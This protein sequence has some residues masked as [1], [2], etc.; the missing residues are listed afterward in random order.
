MNIFFVV[1]LVLL[2]CI[3]GMMSFPLSK[4]IQ[5]VEDGAICAKCGCSDKCFALKSFP[6]GNNNWLDEFMLISYYK[7]RRYCKSAQGD[8]KKKYMIYFIFS[9]ILAMILFWSKGISTSSICFGISS[10]MLLALGIVDWNTQYIPLEYTLVITLCGLIRLFADFTNW[11]EYIIGLLAVS[12][13]LCIVNWIATPILRKKYKDDKLSGVIGDGDIKLMAA[14]GLLIGWKLN[15]IAL[16]VA[17]VIG[18]V[19][20]LARMRIKGSEPIFA[21]GP[22]LSVGVYIT[23]IYGEQLVSWYLEMLGVDPLL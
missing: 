9:V 10:A 4:Y 17:C 1:L 8:Y 2:A 22:Y 21:L 6:V 3:P 20:H 16:G 7:V 12:G 15:F 18:S 5:S 23:M 11:V 14:T 19:I 13:F